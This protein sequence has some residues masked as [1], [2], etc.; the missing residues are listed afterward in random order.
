VRSVTYSKGRDFEL[1]LETEQEIQLD[2]D[3]WGTA[4]AVHSRVAPGALLVRVPA[5]ATA[6]VG[7]ALEGRRRA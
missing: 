4:R 2:G 1:R 5:T 3:E 6:A 7:R